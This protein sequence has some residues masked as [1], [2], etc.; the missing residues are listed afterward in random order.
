MTI[1]LLNDSVPST[2]QSAGGSWRFMSLLQI[3]SSVRFGQTWFHYSSNNLQ[4]SL[5]E[6]INFFVHPTFIS[7]ATR[8]C[9]FLPTDLFFSSPHIQSTK[10][11]EINQG[12]KDD[13]LIDIVTSFMKDSKLWSSELQKS[14]EKGQPQ[15][16]KFTHK[17][18]VVQNCE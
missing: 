18:T 15:K 8:P 3:F 12:N 6:H 7:R 4:I 9:N 13:A 11:K 10:T 2:K 16:V 17:L 1:R 5:N 14:L